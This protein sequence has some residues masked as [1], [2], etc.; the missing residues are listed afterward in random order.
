[1]KTKTK[2]AG[3]LT[4]ETLDRIRKHLKRRNKI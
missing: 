2:Y 1:M 4:Q 3:K